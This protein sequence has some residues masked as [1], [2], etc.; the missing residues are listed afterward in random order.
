MFVKDLL[1]DG[2]VTSSLL[3]EMLRAFFDSGGF[4]GSPFGAI[5]TLF[6]RGLEMK[7]DLF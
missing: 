4:S 3:A 5:V 2:A 6:E 1:G 7:L